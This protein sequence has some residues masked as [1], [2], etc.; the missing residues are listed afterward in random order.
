MYSGLVNITVDY[1]RTNRKTDTV[2]NLKPWPGFV[3]HYTFM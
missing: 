2:K 1:H 3:D